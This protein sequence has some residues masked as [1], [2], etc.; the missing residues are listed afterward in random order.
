MPAS[1]AQLAANRANAQKSTGPRTPE[2]KAAVRYNAV[3]HGMRCDPAALP[4]EDPAVVAARACAWNEAYEPRTP[5]SQ[6]LLNECVGAT[7]LSDRIAAYNAAEVATQIAEAEAAWDNARVDEVEE[8][9]ERLKHDPADARF[10][11]AETAAGCR[12]LVLRWEALLKALDMGGKWNRGQRSEAVR[13]MGCKPGKALRLEPEA[14]EVWLLGALMPAQPPDAEIA[15][16][17]RDD[18]IPRPMRDRYRLDD[19]PR[20]T[21]ALQRL[22]GIVRAQLAE[23]RERAEWLHETVDVPERA[24]VAQRNMILLGDKGR[25]F[26]RYH[27]EARNTFHR[28]CKALKQAIA[29]EQEALEALAAGA[30]EPVAGNS[31]NKPN[32]GPSAAPEPAVNPAQLV[33]ENSVVEST[34]GPLSAAEL[35]RFGAELAAIG[36]E[37]EPFGSDRSDAELLAEAQA[38]FG[39]GYDSPAGPLLRKI[40]A[41]LASFAA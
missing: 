36:R 19:L 5:E 13:L 9:G 7:L 27:A 41:F 15:R 2:G 3:T 35:A 22:T 23:L 40:D 14:W 38:C 26:L 24:A 34:S 16:G 32:F 18:R 1:A 8:H 33:A 20:D 29:A 6:H 28:A 21:E 17:F 25:L 10:C 39:V 30:P 4:N 37:L 11:L 12:W 31:P